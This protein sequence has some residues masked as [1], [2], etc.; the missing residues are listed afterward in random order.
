MGVEESR[1]GIVVVKNAEKKKVLKA[2]MGKASEENVFCNLQLLT[3]MWK[4]KK[5]KKFKKNERWF[6]ICIG[7]H[8]T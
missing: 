1:I 2:A 6:E 5:S 8:V 3:T 4:K 7:G